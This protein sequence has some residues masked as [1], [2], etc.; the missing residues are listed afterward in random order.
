[1][2]DLKLILFQSLQVCLCPYTSHGHCGILNSDGTIDNKSSIKRLASV[3]LSYV[4]AGA[5]IVAP[6]D[7]M[8][9]RVGAIKSAL[10]DSGFGNKASVLSYSAK[11]AS[12]FYG[13][14]RDAAKSAPSFGDR[15]AYQ[16]PP[17][18]SGLAKRAVDRDVEEGADM[19]MVKPGLPYLDVLK[20]VKDSYPEYPLYVYQVSGK[21]FFLKKLE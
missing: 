1:M 3:A 10:I 9:G 6:S 7:M 19:L 17:G 11:F 18:S 5:H 15:K 13:P 8:D 14:F 21:I 12:C 4:K 20:T 16:L 2:Y